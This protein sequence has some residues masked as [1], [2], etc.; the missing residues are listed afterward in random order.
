LIINCTLE[1]LPGLI[2]TAN[3]KRKE[4][5]EAAI[6]EAMLLGAEL[7]A[8]DAPKAFGALQQSFHVEGKAIVADAPYAGLVEL[9]TRPHMPPFRPLLDWA[10]R[11]GA[12]DPGALAYAVQQ[13]IAEVGSQPTNFVKSNIPKLKES[14]RELVERALN[15][16]E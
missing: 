12:N 11:I 4:R 2:R 9:G 5:I 13:K 6:A 3:G 10:T 16:G 1:Q 15:R 8:Q 7:L 14:L